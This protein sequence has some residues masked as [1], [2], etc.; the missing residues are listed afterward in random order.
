MAVIAVIIGSKVVD[1]IEEHERLK[2]VMVGFFGV[3]G[4][5]V[6]F[7]SYETVRLARWLIFGTTT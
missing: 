5:W 2:A 4:L 7:V 1:L 6:I 3:L